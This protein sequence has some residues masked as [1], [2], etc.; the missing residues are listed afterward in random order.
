VCGIKKKLSFEELE[1]PIIDQKMTPI[2]YKHQVVY[3]KNR[4][5]PCIR[6]GGTILLVKDFVKYVNHKY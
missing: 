4:L 5:K 6:S 1:K 2:V 3:M